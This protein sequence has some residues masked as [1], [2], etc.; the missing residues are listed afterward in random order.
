V[1][2]KKCSDIKL[3]KLSQRETSIIKCER[4]LL[5][6]SMKIRLEAG[7]GPPFVHQVKYLDM[8]F[9]KRTT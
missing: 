1:E 7:R 5:T 2:I 6:E 4:V 9:N 3:E 8:I